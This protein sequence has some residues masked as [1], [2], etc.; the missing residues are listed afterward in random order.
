MYKRILVPLDGSAPAKAVVKATFECAFL[1][2]SV[3]SSLV[4]GLEAETQTYRTAIT[5]GVQRESSQ[6]FSLTG[7]CS[8][9]EVPLAVVDA[10]IVNRSTLPTSVPA[11]R[12]G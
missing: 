9:A 4:D 10:R 1:E 12:P 3:V 2:P 11:D 6:T 7:T 8:T 5:D